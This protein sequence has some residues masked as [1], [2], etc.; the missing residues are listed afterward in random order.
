MYEKRIDGLLKQLT[1]EEKID[2]IHGMGLFQTKGVKRL[3]I[4][5]LKMADGPMGVR[6]DFENDRWVAISNS[7]DYVTYLPSGHAIA[8]SWNTELAYQYGHVLGREARGRGKDVILAPS[9]NIIRSPLCGRNFEY[10]SEDPYLTQTFVVPMVKG[11]QSSDVSSC[12]KHFAANNQ[13]TARTTVDV[14]VSQKALHEIYLKA[15]KAAVQ[16]GNAYGLMGAYN[17]INGQYCSQSQI[18]LDEILRDM[19]GY[20]HMVITDWG[21][22]TDTMEAAHSGIDIEMS[23]LNNF[24]DYFMA[25][26]LLEKVK[27]KEIDEVHIDKK[28]R[29]IL[30]VMF[31]LHM[32]DDKH[33]R[34]TGAYNTPHHRKVAYDIAKETVV[35]LKNDNILP[36]DTKVLKK[37]L[38]V[39]DNANRLHA[40]Q[41]GSAEIKALYEITPLMALKSKLGGNVVIDYLP[42]YETQNVTQSDN[43][44]ETSLNSEI[45]AKE[46]NHVAF[47]ERQEQM[48]KAVL[49]CAKD[50]DT[51]LFFGGINHQFDLENEDRQ[52]MLLPYEQDK[53][54]LE[55]LKVQPN[56]IIT[57]LSGA[58]VDMH[59][60]AEK[61]K[62]IL[63]MSYNGMEGGNALIDI[64]LGHVNP[65]GKLTETFARQLTDYPSHSV[66]EFPG[67]DEVHY[68]EGNMVGYRHFLNAQIKPLYAFG[69]GLS[70]TK[71]KYDDYQINQTKDSVIISLSIQNKGQ[72]DGSD[73]VQ[74]Y[75]K[76]PNETQD[77]HA[78]KAFKKIHVKS[79]DKEKVSLTVAIN[80]LSTY[81]EKEKQ[82]TLKK[83]RYIFMVAQSSNQIEK[84]FEVDI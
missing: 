28:V 46:N 26:P 44:Q 60:W 16:E 23:V 6:H 59:Q 66:G 51:V 10:L 58:A 74:I 39:G 40:N 49:S 31:K 67:N 32:I 50:Y 75:V 9:V 57:M 41:G 54:I 25:K 34:N 37:I 55:L 36:L 71:F 2:M 63:W 82:F 30:R 17:K 52:N 27:N 35:L 78:L 47:N 8:S 18:L 42:G 69:H 70:Y 29:N 45:S 83:G 20:E 14:I 15:F 24:D 3:G 84:M 43:W 7:D 4:P 13:E 19:W 38:V 80:E 77:Y 33:L 68:S 11:I 56:T 73:V 79:G 72:Y 81:D 64:I 12:V 5:P 65:S 1:L 21:A 53:L 61:A 22:V 62:A 48:R 76:D